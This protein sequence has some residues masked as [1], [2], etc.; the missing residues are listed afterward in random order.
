M[1]AQFEDSWATSEPAI[2][3]FLICGYTNILTV[4]GSK[5][6]DIY[7][8]SSV[9]NIDFM[10]LYALIDFI[11]FSTLV[12]YDICIQHIWNRDLNLLLLRYTFSSVWSIV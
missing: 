8:S 10:V 5:M 1:V 12:Q 3:Y 11:G 2:Q 9:T 6:I 4:N 7:N